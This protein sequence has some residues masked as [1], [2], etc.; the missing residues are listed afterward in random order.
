MFRRDE[1]ATLVLDDVAAGGL[2]GLALPDGALDDGLSR[3]E[4]LV[5]T[6]VAV[7]TVAVFGFEFAEPVGAF[8]ALLVGESALPAP[9]VPK[10]DTA[11]GCALGSD[12][13]ITALTT[14][15]SEPPTT[16]MI[17]LVAFCKATGQL[18]VMNLPSIRSNKVALR[19]FSLTKINRSASGRSMPSKL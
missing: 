7:C 2:L 16:A 11:G 17:K 4:K 1:G 8:P 14:N 15:K 10:V 9:T 5:V 18:R 13:T 12:K 3:S 6:P 19:R